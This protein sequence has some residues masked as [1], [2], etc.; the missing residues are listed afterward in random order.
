[1]YRSFCSTPAWLSDVPSGLPLPV[2]VPDAHRQAHGQEELSGQELGS[3]GD[4]GVHVYHLLR[5]NWNSDSEP[6]DRGP[7]V[8]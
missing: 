3:R 1:M 7:H 2:G 4:L 5:Q 6:D 8:V